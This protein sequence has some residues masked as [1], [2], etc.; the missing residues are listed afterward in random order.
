MRNSLI[1]ATALPP[2]RY[3][4]VMSTSNIW[5]F[6]NIRKWTANWMIKCSHYWNLAYLY[7]VV[8][9]ITGHKDIWRSFLNS[10][11][12]V[13]YQRTVTP[14][15]EQDCFGWSLNTNVK[16]LLTEWVSDWIWKV[17]WC[18]TISPMTSTISPMTST[19]SPMTSISPLWTSTSSPW[20]STTL[21]R[22]S[23]SSPWTST[24]SPWTS[25][26]SPWTS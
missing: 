11:S 1:N 9:T 25:T 19:T 3:C 20:T 17:P 2:L 8:A 24:S 10:I 23:T 16:S 12:H 4:L 18:S 7:P 26:S 6:N 22:T 5:R 13:A 21:P 15:N 14:H